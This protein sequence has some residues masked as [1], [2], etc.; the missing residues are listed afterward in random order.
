MNELL[1]STSEDRLL[2][3]LLNFH[4]FN[5]S[6]DFMLNCNPIVNHRKILD[7]LLAFWRT[8]QE[9]PK[10]YIVCKNKVGFQDLN[11]YLNW[12]DRKKLKE[13]TGLLLVTPETLT[14]DVQYMWFRDQM[15]NVRD[16]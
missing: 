6:D 14:T 2:E 5:I 3:K 9:H 4:Q 12:V 11:A 8:L 15:S 16:I 1:L 10:F 13:A 7:R